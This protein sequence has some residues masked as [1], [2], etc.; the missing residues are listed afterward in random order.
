MRKSRVQGF[1]NADGLHSQI[2]KS[3]AT[4]F[5]TGLLT[6]GYCDVLV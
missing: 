1:Y 4:E 6:Q 3:R 2:A 5:E